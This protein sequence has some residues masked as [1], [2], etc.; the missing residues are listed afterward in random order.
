M[1][2]L[3]LLFCVNFN[4]ILF[5]VSRL[6]LQEELWLEREEKNPG[7]GLA[8]MLGYLELTLHWDGDVWGR[9]CA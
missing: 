6:L 8:L 4:V 1:R 2:R 9:V 3:A 5:V 7:G